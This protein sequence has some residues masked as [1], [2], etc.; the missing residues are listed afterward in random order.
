MLMHCKMHNNPKEIENETESLASFLT[1]FEKKLPVSK[2][3][4]FQND[5]SITF[6]SSFLI[7]MAQ[8][9]KN[10]L[11]SINN[12][13]RLSIEK[14]D[15]LEFKKYCVRSV[16]LD[17]KKIDSILNT[18]LHYIHVNIPII[19]RNTI[20]LILEEILEAHEHPLQVK[21]IRVVK[22]FEENLP[23]TFVHE[24]HVKFIFNSIFQ[25]A[26]LST[27]R[28]GM[29][30][31]LTKSIHQK[32]TGEDKIIPLKDRKYIEILIV[33]SDHEHS[34]EQSEK[35]S[36]SVASEDE[37]TFGLILQLIKELVQ[38]SQGL[39]EFEVDKK[40]PKTFFSIRLPGDRRKSVYYEP[41]KL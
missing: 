27:P 25:Y 37:K 9:I 18:L 15:D 40:G 23:E 30:R 34:L 19:K 11:V 29:I 1:D 14:G 16:S 28:D 35:I 41:T 17:I 5:G 3:E 21:N 31:F 2:E 6:S 33:L 13:N 24:E 12:V 22:N 32:G 36:E 26:I 7:D 10:T 38:R 8:F 39:I 4:N 20:H